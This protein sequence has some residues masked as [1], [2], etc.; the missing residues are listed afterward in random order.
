MNERIRII[1]TLLLKK[2][3][4]KMAELAEELN[5]TRR[6]INYAINQFNQEL[7]GKGVP[8]IKRNHIGD[9]EIPLDVIQILANNQPDQR[10]VLVKAYSDTERIALSLVY[11]ITNTEY[12]S[13][14]HLTDILKVS[15]NT[16]QEDLK[17]A[18]W[19]VEKYD[20]SLDYNRNQGYQIKGKEQRILQILS[21]LI[22]QNTLFKDEWVKE[23][24]VAEVTD[25][26][27][28]NII[29]S[30][31]QM[32]HVSYSDESIDYLQATVRFVLQ[33]SV[34]E[35]NKKKVFLDGNIRS[36]PEYR[37]LKVIL[38]ESTL[39]IGQSYIEWL[40]VLFLT[41]N[42]SERN[43]T[44]EYQSD[45]NLKEL[46]NEMVDK[47]Q[48][49]TLINID[50]REVFEQRILNHLRP[51]CFRIEYGLSLGGYSLESLIQDSNHAILNE[52]MKELIVPTE[53]WL[54]RAFPYDELELLSYYFGFQLT[55]P[56]KVNSQKPRGVVVCANGVM[57][58]KLMGEN[59]KKL[60]P[61]VHFLSSFSVRDFYKYGKDYDVVFTTT[62]LQSYLP[63]FIIS[64]IMTYKEQISL[65]YRVLTDLGIQDVDNSVDELIHII[66]K[67]S[68]SLSGVQEMREELAYFL[69][70]EKQDSPLENLKTLPDLTQYLKPAFIKMTSAELT[71]IEAV[72]LACKPLLDHQIITQEFITDCIRQ[73]G[74][75]DY[76][77]YLGIRTCIPHTTL[78]HGILKDGISL[79]V[80]KNPIEFPNGH[81]IS[82]IAPLSF[83]D[84]TK[85]L[86]AVN[87]IADISNDKKL[88][89]SIL[90]TKDEKTI[91]Q[92]IRQYT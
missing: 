89:D 88:L 30:M 85:H 2:P 41:S 3:E 82:F 55:S 32:L 59:L 90:T 23:I 83:Y 17:K 51:A 34:T 47:F 11:I 91:Y 57:V 60:F 70:R 62:P 13:L 50:N 72:E 67:Y 20:L 52:L 56:R 15:K 7:E 10:D 19:L 14:D 71:W 44:Q 81:L 9:F 43:T 40:A 69:L 87:Q 92:Q 68:P 29:H 4:I 61:E 33:R 18:N 45:R 25:K 76:S 65:R 21:D 64:P 35:L 36:H 26:E 1:L 24:L 22:R 84:L 31:E 77:G 86:R 42:I 66:R 38:Q 63:Q 75:Q 48:K 80:S 37:F 28:L 5:F 49:Q 6:Q 16:V 73:I 58:S 79:L 54:N 8:Q 78:E 53:D 46:I 74:A 12:V 39:E 27:T